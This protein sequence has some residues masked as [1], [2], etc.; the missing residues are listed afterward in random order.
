MNC[1]EI[2]SR[3]Q[4]LQSIIFRLDYR[5]VRIE[6]VPVCLLPGGLAVEIVAPQELSGLKAHCCH[7]PGFSYPT[8]RGYVYRGALTLKAMECL[9]RSLVS[10]IDGQ[11]FMRAHGDEVR[12]IFK[13]VAS[14]V[15]RDA[16]REAVTHGRELYDCATF[17]RLRGPLLRRYKS[18]QLT[19]TEYQS[20][21]KKL[22][23]PWKRH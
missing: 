6:A 16:Y 10:R 21:L 22:K 1:N 7:I 3:H 23:Q 20:A 13:K 17:K 4:E 19:Q 12:R 8:L 2:L 14:E 9:H 18:R 11:L 15:Y 5:G